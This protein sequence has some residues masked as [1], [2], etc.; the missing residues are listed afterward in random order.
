MVTRQPI[1]MSSRRRKP[2]I[3]DAATDG[4]ALAEP[5][6]GD[7]LAGEADHRL[8]ARDL[9]HGVNRRLQVFL[10]LDGGPDSH[11]DHDLF[12][13]GQGHPVRPTQRLAQGRQN[14]LFV[15]LL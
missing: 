15:F 11:A 13:T 1:A 10:F 14:L 4:H 12:Q 6:P 3:G 2:A 7:R 8:L 5:E 9:G